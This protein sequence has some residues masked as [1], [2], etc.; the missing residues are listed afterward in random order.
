[1]VLSELLLLRLQSIFSKFM[2]N[3]RLY[4]MYTFCV[5]YKSVILIL[6]CVKL[7]TSLVMSFGHTIYSTLMFCL[8]FL[9]FIFQC[10]QGLRFF[11]HFIPIMSMHTIL[12]FHLDLLPKYNLGMCLG[13]LFCFSLHNTELI[14]F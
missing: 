13:R 4:S 1:M 3:L 10:L 2:T 14:P 11:Y 9:R 6:I 12:I 7:I 5:V 8:Q